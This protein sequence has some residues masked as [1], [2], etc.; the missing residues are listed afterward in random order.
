[1]AHLPQQGE[2]SNNQNT[3][4]QWFNNQVQEKKIDNPKEKQMEKTNQ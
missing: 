4:Q 1:M 3:N 2:N